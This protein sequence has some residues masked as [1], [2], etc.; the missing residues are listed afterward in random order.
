M[1]AIYRSTQTQF[2]RTDAQTQK[3]TKRN[4]TQTVNYKPGDTEKRLNGKVACELSERIYGAS[5]W[6][7]VVLEAE[8]ELCNV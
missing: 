4:V 1:L 2:E 3:Q 8:T 5:A 7:P 6:W